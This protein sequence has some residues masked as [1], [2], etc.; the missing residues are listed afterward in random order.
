MIDYKN[1]IVNLTIENL[2]FNAEGVAKLENTPVFVPFALPG[3]LVKVK[4]IKQNKNFFIGKLQEVINKSKHR[5]DAPC[6]VFTKCGGCQLQH[7]N[8]NEQLEFK[9]SLVKDTLKKVGNIVYDKIEIVSSKNKYN[10]RNK[11]TL[12]VREVLNE[13]KIGFFA[14]HS[15]RIVE[16]DECPLQQD[17]TNKVITVFK[18]FIKSYK[19]SAYN[20]LTKKGL[21]KNLVARQFNDQLLVAVI[22]NGEQLP[23]AEEFYNLLK[24]TFKTVTLYVNINKEHNNVVIGKTSKLIKGEPYLE[25]QL[26]NLN[27]KTEVVS[28]MQ[29]NNDIR[30]KIYNNVLEKI[31]DFSPQAVVD[32]YS[33]VGLLTGIIA[34]NVDSNVYGLEI[35]PKAVEASNKLLKEN[36][37]QNKVTN[38]L[39]DC[40]E[41]LPK[42]M[43]N[44]SK[45]TLVVDPPRKG[46]NKQI[47]QTILKVKPKQIIY[48]A[49]GLPALARD[50]AYLTNTKNINSEQSTNKAIYKIKDVKAYDM[51]PQTKHIETVVE[52]TLI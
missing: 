10:Y 20:E 50:L 1:K 13:V 45:T 41:T 3:E 9:S 46:L 17:L 12:Q 36:N 4:I 8:Y 49:C 33:G 47:I 19:V 21:V 31:K 16:V 11:L 51:F 26:Q 43:K 23:N 32:A 52:L 29:V 37:L 40:V 18:S 14:N 22:I 34:K 28:F 7:L 24:Q 44:N 5:V 27:V 48:I 39:G 15:H 38:V 2:G 6:S 42:V 25:E 30:N 35:Q